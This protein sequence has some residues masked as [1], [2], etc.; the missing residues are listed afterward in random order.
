M[1][2]IST[3]ILCLFFLVGSLSQAAEFR[4]FSVIQG[5]GDSLIPKG[6]TPL[7]TFEP[8]DPEL[9]EAAFKKV[10]ENYTNP[11]L[12]ENL[13]ESFYD[14]DRLLQTIAEVVPRDAV[15]ELLT[16]L[17]S[18]QTLQQ[19]R[20]PNPDGSYTLVSIVSFVAQTRLRFN[21][22]TGIRNSDGTNEYRVEV[23]QKG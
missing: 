10:L 13:G 22:S 1:K 19:Y 21:T 8:V 20:L 5:Q 3:L 2:Y 16:P 23:R 9:L 12:S 17:S 14:K 15:V 18:V 4:S 11:K 6:A 7:E